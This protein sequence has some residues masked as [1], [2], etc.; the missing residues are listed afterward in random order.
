MNN[1]QQPEIDYTP[2]NY[3]LKEQVLYATKFVA[4]VGIFFALI[5]WFER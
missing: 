1:S 3:S 5:W 2:K 4:V